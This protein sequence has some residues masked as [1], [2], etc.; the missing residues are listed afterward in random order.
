MCTVHVFVCLCLYSFWQSMFLFCTLSFKASK[1]SLAYS[2]STCLE[3]CPCFPACTKNL[4]SRGR[5]DLGGQTT[6]MYLSVKK[7]VSAQSVG[8]VTTW[9]LHVCV[10]QWWW[11][12][13]VCDWEMSSEV[14]VRHRHTHTHVNHWDES[15]S[16]PHS[17]LRHWRAAC[18]KPVTVRGGQTKKADMVQPFRIPCINNT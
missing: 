8:R 14:R 15:L 6:Q 9:T 2:V 13:P 10:C 11:C 12:T 18:Y 17:T 5:I 16:R 1:L 4:W 3:A 7:T